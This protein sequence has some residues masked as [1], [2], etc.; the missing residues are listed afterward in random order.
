MVPN[1]ADIQRI[2]TLAKELLDNNV[3]ST[4]EEAFA[5]ATST[6]TSRSTSSSDHN[7]FLVLQSALH[8][9]ARGTDEIKQELSTL[10]EQIRVIHDTLQSLPL[11]QQTEQQAEQQ[12]TLDE[13]ANETA[14]S[15]DDIAIDKVF[16]SGQK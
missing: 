10:K 13:P 12:T 15:S 9:L 8:A 2:N 11:S 5:K 1:P 3:V 7:N 14:Y 6:L 16:Y 4:S